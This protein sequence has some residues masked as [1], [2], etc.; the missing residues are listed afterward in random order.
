MYRK[1]KWVKTQDPSIEEIRVVELTDG[2]TDVEKGV[3]V[4]DDCLVA[5]KK[6]GLKG[7]VLSLRDFQLNE[8]EIN[9][10]PA[11]FINCHI[12]DAKQ[13]KFKPLSL[14]AKHSYLRKALIDNHSRKELFV[15]VANECKQEKSKENA[16]RI[17]YRYHV[18]PVR[19]ELTTLLAQIEHEDFPIYGAD[20]ADDID[21]VLEG[22]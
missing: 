9:G 4:T 18:S 3:D 5:R 14:F 6:A 15:F 17:F 11:W 13:K 20:V 16:F 2:E 22:F 7:Y 10:S 12:F 19:G 8:V 1:L 21:I